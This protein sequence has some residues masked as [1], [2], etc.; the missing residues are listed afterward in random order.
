M[1]TQEGKV[2]MDFLSELEEL[3]KEIKPEPIIQS[4]TR[5]K[6]ELS[7]NNINNNKKEKPIIPP[8]SKENEKSNDNYDFKMNEAMEQL[9]NN[10]KFISNTLKDQ[11]NNENV[12]PESINNPFTETFSKMINE[13]NSLNFEEMNKIFSNFPGFDFPPQNSQ[14]SHNP[15]ENISSPPNNEEVQK[16]ICNDV[17]ELL[18]STNLLSE[19]I[20]N[21]KKTIQSSFTKNKE[22]LTKEEIEKYNQ[23]IE[24]ADNILN[25][26]QKV[27]PN[28]EIIVDM[29][30]HL[31]QITEID[32]II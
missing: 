6:E 15:T 2:D 19:T 22:T 4:E 14:N 29:L 23:S 7:S 5:K 21:M 27:H 10:L 3:S 25:E 30:Y 31:Q 9:E 16:K 20:T 26:S 17:L 24:Y 28:K 1:E 8:T 32:S 12:N 13:N 11:L 18:L